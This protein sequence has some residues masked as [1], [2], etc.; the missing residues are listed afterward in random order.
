MSLP[1]FKAWPKIPRRN[2]P[3]IVTEKIDGSNGIIHISEE[4]VVT[5][6]SRNRWLVDGAEN[7]GFAVWVRQHEEELRAL[8]TGYH[9]GEW[10]GAGIQRGYDLSERRFALFNTSRWNNNH[11]P[12]ACCS[13]VPVL[14]IGFESDGVIKRLL[15]E[16]IVGG[17]RAVPGFMKPEGIVVFHTAAGTFQK[18]LIENDDKP[19]GEAEAA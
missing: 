16:L 8:G 6:G 1:E 7:Y 5:A 13:V 18:V 3:V 12:P 9:Y 11:P 15:D 4:G 10:F 19:K 14:G 17:S 2:K